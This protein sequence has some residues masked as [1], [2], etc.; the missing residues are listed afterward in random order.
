MKIRTGFVSNSSSSSFVL[1]VG[2]DLHRKIIE[3][4]WDEYK[5]KAMMDLESMGQFKKINDKKCFVL[6]GIQWEGGDG[7]TEEEDEK[8]ENLFEF[9]NKYR[10]HLRKFNENQ[11]VLVEESW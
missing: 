7:N 5:Q 1:V 2:E 3:M 6:Q 11:Y 9:Y 10:K 4:V 8:L